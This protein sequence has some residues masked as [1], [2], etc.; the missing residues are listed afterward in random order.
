M[1]EKIFVEYV[2]VSENMDTVF[3]RLQGGAKTGLY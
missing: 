2:L 3:Y 1:D